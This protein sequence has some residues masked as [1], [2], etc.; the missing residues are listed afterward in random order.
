MIF[1]ENTTHAYYPISRRLPDL[2]RGSRRIR[3]VRGF[4][5]TNPKGSEAVADS[6]PVLVRAK[7]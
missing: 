3:Y 4:L 1:C 2:I 7:S 5:L 6:R